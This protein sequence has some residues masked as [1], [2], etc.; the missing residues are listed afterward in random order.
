M[1]LNT[2]NPILIH[3]EFQSCDKSL[4]SAIRIKATWLPSLIIWQ[5]WHGG[6][7]PILIA[8]KKVKST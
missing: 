6:T 8:E 2:F 4:H 5:N 1:I 7:N 3:S